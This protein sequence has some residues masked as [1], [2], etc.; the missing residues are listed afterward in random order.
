MDKS[1]WFDDL[2]LRNYCIPVMCVLTNLE[3]NNRCYLSGCSILREI[4]RDMISYAAD[5]RFGPVITFLGLPSGTG[6]FRE[7]RMVVP[8]LLR[9]VGAMIN[10]LMW[11]VCTTLRPPSDWQCN[12]YREEGRGSGA[13][14]QHAPLHHPCLTEN[15]LFH[16]HP[17]PPTHPPPFPPL[18]NLLPLSS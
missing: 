11:T 14:A 12:G 17:P 5:R 6:N 4:L 2:N 15:L 13:C 10:N 3:L 7:P 18:F 16:W 9:Y 8:L 1:G